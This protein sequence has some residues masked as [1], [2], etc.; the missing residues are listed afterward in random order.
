MV[1]GYA[2]G[3]ELVEAQYLRDIEIEQFLARRREF[4]PLAHHLRRDEK[5]RGD[6]VDWDPL[7]MQ[8]LE[9]AELIER[10]QSFAHHIL[11]ER[12]LFFDPFR[13]D[14]AGNGR[15]LGETL[16]LHQKFQ[17][18]QPASA[19]AHREFAAL[20]AVFAHSWPHAQ[21]L[22]QDAVES[23]AYV[24]SLARTPQGPA[25]LGRDRRHRPDRPL[26]R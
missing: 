18:R 12:I 14:D 5:P 20:L 3:A 22:Q 21:R 1:V 11:G 2:R 15:V 23:V 4:Q 9:R 10:M 8:A 26:W 24:S 7:I 13:L 25:S 16:L 17:R 19:G 6:L